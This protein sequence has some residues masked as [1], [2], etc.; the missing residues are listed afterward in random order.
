MRIFLHRS[1]R[2]KRNILLFLI[3]SVLLIGV[4]YSLI[5]TNIS[6]NGL[7][8]VDKVTWDVHFENVVVDNNN[9]TVQGNINLS[10]NNTLINY[11]VTLDKPGD[12][13]S[14]TVDV[15]NNGTIDAM[16]ASIEPEG[17]T[18][19]QK[20]IISYSITYS[21][22][23]AL[24]EKD[25]L[26]SSGIERLVVKL[27]YNYD[28][29][30]QDLLPS[31]LTVHLKLKTNYVQDDGTSNARPDSLFTLMAKAAVPDN[32]SSQ[33]VTSSNGIDFKTISSDSNGKGIYLKAD[34]KTDSRP[35]YYYR[36]A[37]TNNNVMFADFC[38][39]IVRTTETG[40]VKLIYNGAP[41]TTYDYDYLDN[42][43][44]INVTNDENYPYTYDTETKYW[45]STNHTDGQTGTLTFSVNVTGDY[46]LSYEV[47]SESCCDKAYF[48][49][50]G[51]QIDVCSGIQ[52]G[53]IELQD[54][55]PSTVFSVRYTKDSSVSNGDDNIK[56]AIGQ[57]VG[58]PYVNCANVGSTTEIPNTIYD[59]A[60]SSMAY[61]GYMYGTIYPYTKTDIDTSAEYLFGNSFTYS[62][63]TYQ[64]TDT[65]STI[66][67]THHYT[68]FNASGECENINYVYNTFATTQ[69]YHIVISDGKSV[70]DAIAEM[71]ANTNNSS[72]KTSIDTWFQNTFSTW[73]TNNGKSY[74]N[75]LEDTVW[76]NDRSMYGEDTEEY[77]TKSG[78]VPNG[79]GYESHLFFSTWG[80]MNAGEPSLKCIKKNDAYT[81]NDTIN[82][83][84]A[85]TYP[86]ALL[87]SDEVMLAGGNGSY[88]STEGHNYLYTG[89]Y[90]KLLSPSRAGY[91]W[92]KPMVTTS[93]AVLD[94]Y[95]FM[96]TGG[97]RPT[98]SINASLKVKEGTN[99]TSTNPYQ[100]I[101]D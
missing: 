83:N 45:I 90:M 91:L 67:S 54:V 93:D 4:G 87:T 76:C 1:E 62:D 43:Y 8:A 58:G 14:F 51:V 56:F 81:V 66:D 80:R 79:G 53:S 48:F 22:G 86:V 74:S 40:G 38:W 59:S 28:L 70:E 100:F 49:R 57:I 64:L 17:L 71:Q 85:L 69:Y 98:I 101:I 50:D 7:L 29:D 88:S 55:T 35:I 6:I 44:Y 65:V 68:C 12:V 60:D 94:D 25:S 3:C 27:E 96:G 82:G 84:G 9:N 42:S 26:V 63:G 18:E 39:K 52:N 78:W 97:I 11:T 37:V 2:K 16:L 24:Q 92:I 75:Y 34:S 99:G 32:V 36:G 19:E 31:N 46:Y 10:S 61:I 77:L 20:K 72:T 30:K 21:D 41:T 15:V 5:A 73:F 47:S 33:F 95:S 89:Q 23:N 13:Y